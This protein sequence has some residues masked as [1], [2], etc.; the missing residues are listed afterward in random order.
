VFSCSKF[1][2]SLTRLSQEKKRM[3]N[4]KI[5]TWVRTFAEKHELWFQCHDELRIPSID[6]MEPSYIDGKMFIDINRFHDITLGVFEFIREDIEEEEWTSVDT[7]RFF[8]LQSSD[9]SNE[10][11]L[12]AGIIRESKKYIQIEPEYITLVEKND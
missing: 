7:I 2:L 8:V 9:F 4:A 3:N 5:K 6:D 1:S 10:E 11:A 12:Y